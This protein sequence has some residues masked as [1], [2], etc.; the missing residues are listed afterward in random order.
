[1]Y[2]ENH[3]WI[4]ADIASAALKVHYVKIDLGYGGFQV[5][6]YSKASRYAVSRSKTSQIR[7]FELVPKDFK[8]CM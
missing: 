8:I 1:M 4:L 2:V 5:K 6:N 3:C 7:R